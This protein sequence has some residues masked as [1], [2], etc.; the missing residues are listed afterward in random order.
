MNDDKEPDI[1]R[2]VLQA[3]E[4]KGLDPAI[5]SAIERSICQQY[6]GRRV[7]IPK[8]KKQLIEEKRQTIFNEALTQKSTKQIVIEQGVSRATLY[9]LMKK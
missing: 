7:Y 5:A 2:L 4:A 9:R 8:R 3:C 1:V 6:G